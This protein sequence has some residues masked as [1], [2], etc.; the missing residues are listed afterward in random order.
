MASDPTSEL[1]DM[2]YRDPS[3]EDLIQKFARNI[4][5]YSVMGGHVLTV[6]DLQEVNHPAT[7]SY[8]CK[9]LTVA[10]YNRITARATVET[11]PFEAL[12]ISEIGLYFHQ[13]PLATL[14]YLKGSLSVNERYGSSYYEYM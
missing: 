1:T 6:T 2:R 9:P 8:H 13:V 11:V 7:V 3:A 5:D 4:R 14:E 10:D 12:T